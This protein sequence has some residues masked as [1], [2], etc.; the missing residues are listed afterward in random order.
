VIEE[1]K[2]SGGF[3]LIEKDTLAELISQYQG[4]A[5]HL[6]EDYEKDIKLS[7]QIHE[8]MTE[9][10][11]FNYPNIADLDRAISVWRARDMDQDSFDFLNKPAFIEAERVQL[12]MLTQERVAIDQ[13]LNKLLIMRRSFDIR[14]GELYRLGLRSKSIRE[15]L[16][17]EFL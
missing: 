1:M 12:P 6:Y 2:S 5:L 14:V 8:L 11:N 9:I 17:E 4:V 16:K 3:Q 10:I 13:L 7:G 15:M